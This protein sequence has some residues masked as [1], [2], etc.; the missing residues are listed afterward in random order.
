M[1]TV[2]ADTPSQGV[3]EGDGCSTCGIHI[4]LPT[5]AATYDFPDGPRCRAALRV[6][7]LA[8]NLVC[9]LDAGVTGSQSCLDAVNIILC[10]HA[11]RM[12]EAVAFGCEDAGLGHREACG[13]LGRDEG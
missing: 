4:I 10:D 6:F 9:A 5:A 8:Q 12:T 2:A 11:T 7:V 13:L 3:L 1:G